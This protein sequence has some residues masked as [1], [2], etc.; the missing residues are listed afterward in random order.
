MPS[1]TLIVAPR[2]RG[3]ETLHILGVIACG[4]LQNHGSGDAIETMFVSRLYG[5]GASEGGKQITLAVHRE[6]Y[7]PF[8]A[9]KGFDLSGMPMMAGARPLVQV[10]ELEAIFSAAEYRLM[11]PGLLYLLG[12]FFDHQAGPRLVA[13][14]HLAQRVCPFSMTYLSSGA[15]AK[16]TI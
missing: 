2:L 16:G 7:R 4:A 3:R 15:C 13:L 6:G 10:Q 9:E 14:W 5:L 1:P 8:Q 12:L 11:P